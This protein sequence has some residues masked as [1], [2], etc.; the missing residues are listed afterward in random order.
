MI[1]IDGPLRF[2]RLTMNGFGRR[3][4]FAVWRLFVNDGQ[5]LMLSGVTVGVALAAKKF[6]RE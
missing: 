1:L 3:R 5:T 4:I 6:S 2:A